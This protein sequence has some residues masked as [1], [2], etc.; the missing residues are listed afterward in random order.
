MYLTSHAG[1]SVQAAR[2]EALSADSLYD[3]ME[4]TGQGFDAGS[5]RGKD[6]AKQIDDDAC[7]IAGAPAAAAMDGADISF[8]VGLLVSGGLYLILCRGLELHA[9]QP[10]IVAS[11]HEL[12]QRETAPAP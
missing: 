5:C 6:A 4:T 8:I 11:D 1:L 12:E 3:I 10:A 7:A 9:E 2:V